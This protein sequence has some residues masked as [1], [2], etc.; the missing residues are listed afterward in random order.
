VTPQVFIL[1]RPQFDKGY[2]AFLNAF[3]EGAPRE[4]HE[5]PSCTAAERLVEF[6]GRVCYMSFGPKQSPKTNEE[7]IR[8]LI[9]NGHESVL[10]HAAWTFAISGVSRAFTHQLVRHRIGF[11]F[12][13]LSQQYHDESDAQFIEPPGIE[14]SPNA[15]A[16]WR[17]LMLESIAAYNDNSAISSN[18]ERTRALRSVARSVLPNATATVIVVSANARSLRHFFKIRGGIIGDV[19]TRLVAAALFKAVQPE[20][21]SLFSDFGLSVLADG[22]PV[23]RQCVSS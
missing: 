1:A 22:Y 6:A 9:Q 4:W 3:Y 21:P 7:Y 16:T 18:K 23:V 10:E 11:S 8:N 14:G 19:E 20:G 5:S 17:R 15:A 2:L 13:Q 12:S